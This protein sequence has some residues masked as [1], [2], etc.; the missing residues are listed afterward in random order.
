MRIK[1]TEAVKEIN[2]DLYIPVGNTT[3]NDP[4]HIDVGSLSDFVENNIKEK[5]TFA[6]TEQIAGLSDAIVAEGENIT[7]ID[8]K[9]TGQIQTIGQQIA[10]LENQNKNFATTEQLNS[11]ERGLQYLGDSLDQLEVDLNTYETWTFE[12]EDGSTI[13]KKVLI[14]K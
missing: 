7:F 5:G 9:F 1:D 2:Y 12:L 8:N 3:T 4:R 10:T 11:V 14:N 13:N 6:T